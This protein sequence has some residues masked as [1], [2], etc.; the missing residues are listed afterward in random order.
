QTTNI[1]ANSLR[2]K[3]KNVLGNLDMKCFS[4]FPENRHACLDIRRLQFGCQTT[5]EARNKSLL[6][7][8]NFA[9]WSIT[10]KH[11]LLTP[12][13]KGIKGVEEFFLRALFAGQEVYIIDQE[14]IRLAVAF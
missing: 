3:G 9:C 5:L 4:L 13:K 1:V 11:D 8:G 14:N 6:Q 7:V 2:E 10:R 12:V